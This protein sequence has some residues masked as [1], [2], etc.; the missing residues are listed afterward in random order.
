MIRVAH[1]QSGDEPGMHAADQIGDMSKPRRLR[2]QP[3]AMS[4]SPVA[5]DDDRLIERH[6]GRVQIPIRR[7]KMPFDHFSWHVDQAGDGAES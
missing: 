4:C 3:K 5:D 6:E 2:W 7:I 1:R